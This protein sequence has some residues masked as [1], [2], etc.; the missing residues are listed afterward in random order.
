MKTF[1]AKEKAPAARVVPPNRTRP[2]RTGESL[3]SQA[4]IRRIIGESGI[5]T[6][7]KVSRPDDPY[8]KEADQVADQVMRMPDLGIRMKSG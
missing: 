8:E 3:D 7:L 5:Q 1:A 2:F 4:D 6:K